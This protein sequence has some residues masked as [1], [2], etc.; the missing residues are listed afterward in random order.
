MR[1]R[2]LLWTVLAGLPFLLTGWVSIQGRTLVVPHPNATLIKARSLQLGEYREVLMKTTALLHSDSV[3]TLEAQL[4]VAQQ[5]IDGQAIGKLESVLPAMPD[6]FGDDGARHEIESAK[7]ELVH[8]LQESGDIAL[9][10]K[11]EAAAFAAHRA[12]LLTA[13][14]GK[15]GTPFSVRRSST[16]QRESIKSLI[17][18]SEFCSDDMRKQIADL[19][20]DPRMVENGV[21][22]MVQSLKS[23]KKAQA[24]ASEV[25][26]SMLL[27]T[28]YAKEP[29]DDPLFENL[30]DLAVMHENATAQARDVLLNKVEAF[31]SASR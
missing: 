21:E 22:T 15:Y 25:R 4:Q 13:S 18:L 23:L 19:C 7:L 17:A 30:I 3:D 5:W 26:P 8:R 9:A 12:A 28:A 20:R 31:L 11:D 1:A 10:A 14:V 6:D 2:T 27:Q 16:V 24:R 29:T